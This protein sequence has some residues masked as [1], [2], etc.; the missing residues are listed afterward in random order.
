VPGKTVY[1][2]GGSSKARSGR[3]SVGV[4]ASP[5]GWT[6][7]STHN[8]LLDDECNTGALWA[9]PDGSIYVGTMSSLA[10]FDPRVSPLPEPA[11]RCFWRR[12]PG[13]NGNEPAQLPARQ[14]SVGLAWSAP[15]LTPH[16]VE[17]R[18]RVPR[19]A[20]GWRPAQRE[21]EL[22]LDGLRPGRWDVAVSARRVGG[23]ESDWTPPIEARFVVLPLWWETLGARL[24]MALLALAAVAAVVRWR[25][26]RVARRAEHLEAEVTRRTAELRQR[27]D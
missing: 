3:R 21:R 15:W 16:P 23:R 12:R 20:A 7:Y 2:L 9:A 24:S 17:Y 8:G 25:T 18:V 26:R 4:A 19:L 14:R 11:L 5:G 27:N 13:G 22:R 10:R 1:S 6:T